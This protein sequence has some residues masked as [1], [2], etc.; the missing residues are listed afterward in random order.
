M[1]TLPRAL[2]WRDL[3]LLYRYR[4][5]ALCLDSRRA[6]IGGAGLVSGALVALF[7]A[8]TGMAVVADEAAEGAP[9][10]GL[11][12]YNPQEGI[13]RLL[14]LAPKTAL[15]P[16]TA[17]TPLVEALLA[18]PA[19]RGARALLADAP[20]QAPWLPALRRASFRVFAR[21]RLWQ[22]PTE[23]A[24][25]RAGRWRWPRADERWAA[26]RLYTNLTPPLVRHLLPPPAAAPTAVVYLEDG[27]VR[28]VARWEAGP[29][30]IWVVPWL[31]PDIAAPCEALRALV[32]FL[33]TGEKPLYIAVREAQVWLEGPLERL[34]ARPSEP[35]ALLARWAVQPQPVA[36]AVP[37]AAQRE[38]PQ[39]TLFAK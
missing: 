22:M 27:E 14:Y 2:T 28:G 6:V 23:H 39:P 1:S 38:A 29:Q 5:Q 30:G 4:E 19:L 8:A 24:E 12:E 36:E 34:D 37:A 33:R 18:H 15:S 10:V 35:L 25:A 11:A 21:Q 26:D 32:A 7:S 13:A 3:P 31:D 16:E 20:Q 9:L 17:L